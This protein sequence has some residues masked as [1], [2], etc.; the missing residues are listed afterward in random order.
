[1]AE[2]S[3]DE[4]GEVADPVAAFKERLKQLRIE[5]GNPSFRELERLF[6]KLGSP[7]SNSAIHAK[8]A[9]TALPDRMFVE[10]FVLACVR[11]AGTGSEPDLQQWRDAHT[12][13]LADVAAREA[14]PTSAGDPYRRLEAFS[15]DDALWFHGRQAAVDQVLAVL[16]TQRP[17]VLLLG[18][19]GAGKSSLVNAAVLPALGHGA[20]PGS[21]RWLRVSVRPRQ[22][23]P[24]ELERAG[25]SGAGTSLPEALGRRLAG[26]PPQCRLLLVI[27]QFEE[28]L[29]PLANP[30]LEQIRCGTL[31]QLTA[32][33]GMPGVTLV[34]VMRDDFYPQLAAQAPELRAGLTLVDLPAVLSV[35]QLRE[36]IVEPARTA[37]L[38]WETGLPERIVA[39]VLAGYDTSTTRCVPVTVL[40]LLELTLYQVWERRAGTRLTRD[41][42]ERIGGV[43]G[44]LTTWC[45]AAIEQLSP[46]ERKCAEQV[47]T[48][49]VRPADTERGVPAVRQQVPVDTLRQLVGPS[50]TDTPE[51]AGE[52]TVD[53]VLAILTGH[54]IVTT[55]TLPAG[56][57]TGPDPDS[58]HEV[59]TPVAELVHDAVIRD[60]PLLREWVDRDHRFQ[61]WLRR[62]DERHRHWVRHPTPDDL[63]HGSDLAEGIDW[64]AHRSLPCGIAAFLRASQDNQQARARRTRRLNAVLA[65]LLAVALA[66]AGVATWQRHRAVDAQRMAL[67]RQ[68][69]AQSTAILPRNPDLAD[70]LSVEAYRI[71]PTDEAV[72]SIYTAVAQPIVRTLTG[73]TNTWPKVVAYSPDG[74]H[75]ASGGDNK[76]VRVWDLDT[77]KSRTMA[78]H[79]KDVY[80]VAY[81]PD[82]RHLA[83]ASG[84]KTVRVWD[85]DTGVSRPLT[86][87]GWVYAVAYSPDGRYLASAGGDGTVR[88]WNLDTGKPRTLAGHTDSVFAVAYSPDGQ[89]LASA[90]RDM[91]V[92]VWDLD[93]GESRILAGHTD[94]VFAV[95]YSP[96]GHRLASAGFDRTVRVWNLDTGKPRILAGHTNEVSAVAYSPDGRHLASASSDKT[97]RVWD[98]DTGESRILASHPGWVY[99]VAYSPDRRHLASAG[100]D[101]TVRVWDLDTGKPRTLAGHTD[102]VFTVAYSPDGRHL[103]S[104]GSDKTVRVWNLDTGESRI[105]AGHTDKVFTVAYSPDGRY[106]ASASGDKTVRVWDLDTGKPRT[107][108]GHTDSVHAVAYSPDRRHL[109]SA[110]YDMTVRVWNLDTGESRILAGHTGWVFAVAYSPDGR[111]LASA[112]SDMT[113]RVWDLDTG[114]SRIL[115]GHTDKVHAVAYSPDRRHL[116]S[117][118]G[119]GT[120][121]VWDLDTGESRILA[122]HTDKVHAVAYSPDGR[123]LAS[124]SGDMTVRVWD[125]DTGKP[126][127]LTGHTKTVY[128]LAYS[129]DG[130]HLASVG[131]DKTVRVWANAGL[132]PAAAIDLICSNLRRDLTP[133]ERKTYLPSAESDVQ[134]CPQPAR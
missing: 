105:L 100:S 16:N 63:L 83:S 34:L 20:L 19:S 38:V 15:V 25:L 87:N 36:I 89:Y 60:W 46:P 10:T 94:K 35:E 81:S 113:V 120:V 22:N 117:A 125:L 31:A 11:H 54:R 33:L 85:L 42:Y 97:V 102:S 53:R 119:D 74:H 26:Q 99:A 6:G 5:C 106:L 127:T 116:A 1:M 75:L 45:T 58:S 129:P 122:G 108:A 112:G 29:T 118:S 66:A 64:S 104:A 92:R 13:M 12:R 73:H 114:E 40:P 67:S 69:A 132:T 130:Y 62:T 17:A 96:D 51:P 39:D 79:T 82:G 9:G 37:G 41:A 72:D 103:A 86:H 23:L 65:C 32:V 134:A 57:T 49:L 47:L 78:G 50:V 48:A 110:G 91:T 80:A 30:D 7:Q 84:D 133:G 3:V 8:L 88:V 52:S 115:A 131:G 18:P 59:R 14:L 124:A 98:L 95:A 93:A 28:L 43:R 109:A 107:L 111:H 90:G 77:G 2:A 4:T 101:M 71:S 76:T 70:L 128:A 27:D 55:R 68:L 121:R 21:D 24:A 123:Y 44:A 61:D 56:H 126:R